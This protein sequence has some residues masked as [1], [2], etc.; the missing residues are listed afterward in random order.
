M[1][2]VLL[3]VKYSDFDRASFYQ[4]IVKNQNIAEE[5]ERLKNI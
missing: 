3:V 2:S 1:Y 5:K 4:K